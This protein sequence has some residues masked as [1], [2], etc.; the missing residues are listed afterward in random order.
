ME[1]I[2][3]EGECRPLEGE[4]E[5]AD[6]R[7]G[8]SAGIHS[9][10]HFLGRQ[11]PSRGMTP[12]LLIDALPTFNG[13]FPRFTEGCYDIRQLL[14]QNVKCFTTDGQWDATL[15]LHV[16]SHAAAVEKQQQKNIFLVNSW[17]QLWCGWHSY[18]LAQSPF[19][20]GSL[21]PHCL[22]DATRSI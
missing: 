19:L 4:T 10:C 18:D 5:G 14:V 8:G 13:G 2:P 16:S 9:V 17:L 15:S 6:P 7:A 1:V 3:R 22:K 20:A 11:C 12:M 21:Q